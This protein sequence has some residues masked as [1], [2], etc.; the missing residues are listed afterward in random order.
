MT[1]DDRIPQVVAI[2]DD[3]TGAVAAAAE[4]TKVG[5]TASVSGWQRAR[6]AAAADVLVVDTNTRLLPETE[7]AERVGA[8]AR[9][10]H[11]AFP[12]CATTFYK[13]VDSLLRGSVGREVEAWAAEIGVP[14]VAAVGAPAYDV[15]TCDGVQCVGGRPLALAEAG[16]DVTRVRPMDLF[17][18]QHLRIAV[19]RGRDAGAVVCRAVSR[20][21]SVSA[22][23]LKLG[24]LDLIAEAA[25]QA[26]RA[27]LRFGLVGSYG[28][29]SAW[30]EASRSHQ[31]RG[32]LVA[33]TSYRPNAVAQIRTFGS[34]PRRSV[35]DLATPDET[36]VPEAAAH[37][38]GGRDVAI[39]SVPTGAPPTEP[40]IAVTG[41]MARSVAAVLAAV[42]PAGL[43][44][45]GG[46]L[47]SALTAALQVDYLQV[48]MEPWAATP[49]LR[50]W[51][52]PQDGLRAVIQS[53]SQGEPAR[54]SQITG[55]LRVL[56]D[57]SRVESEG[58]SD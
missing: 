39:S 30:L 51:G 16:Q 18:G 1:T 9:R 19:V 21:E 27:G 12:D 43:V 48:V 34:G 54:L 58:G 13:R 56:A 17:A 57:G 33:S 26:R 38:S 24:D 41:R 8:V 50:L 46:E 6:G 22:D 55:V 44:V 11:A 37:L 29:L 20:G 10:L 14:V 23:V 47:A 35:L 36:L 52:G 4:A 31:R 2:S 7:A 53:G 5:L 28:L 40:S 3:L 25:A 49:V 32:V 15:T 42:R 45:V